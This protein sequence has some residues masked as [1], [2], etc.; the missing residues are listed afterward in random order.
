MERASFL[1]F[2]AML[3]HDDSEAFLKFHKAKDAYLALEPCDKVFREIANIFNRLGEFERKTDYEEATEYYK[4]SAKY[5]E[6]AVKL[7]PSPDTYCYFAE[8]CVKIKDDRAAELFIEAIELGSKRACLHYGWF[9]H[10]KK[11]FHNALFFYRLALKDEEELSTYLRAKIVFNIGFLYHERFLD[12]HIQS[13]FDE[14]E[15]NYEEANMLVEGQDDAL[16]LL[17]MLRSG[18]IANFWVEYKRLTEL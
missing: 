9:L 14:A 11:E 6:K 7:K 13:H 12:L 8:V 2:D 1:C 5:Y 4:E 10:K 17:P 18:C 16:I 15:K 3:T